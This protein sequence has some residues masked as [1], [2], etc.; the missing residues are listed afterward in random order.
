MTTHAHNIRLK[1][2]WGDGSFEDAF[3]TPD[4]EFPKVIDWLLNLDSPATAARSKRHFLAQPISI[5]RREQLARCVA[6]LIARSPRFRNYLRLA[7]EPAGNPFGAQ[8]FAPSETLIAMNLRGCFETFA[9]SIGAAGTFMVG[10]SDSR[11]FIFGDGFFSNFLSRDAPLCPRVL[12]PLT[13]SMVLLYV[14]PIAF[15]IPPKLVTLR[16]RDD[17]VAFV[18]ETIQV[19]SKDQLFFRCQKPSI[20]E[21]F[22]IHEFLEFTDDYHPILEKL[23]QELLAFR[24]T[25]RVRGR[26]KHPVH[27]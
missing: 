13:P 17:E 21:H 5:E 24:A 19:Y 27:N 15:V 9:R 23:I 20:S 11:E 22:W 4:G 12:L 3:G 8:K 2:P 16:L 18:N 26:T 25:P 14:R 1:S 10:F 7:V 6:S